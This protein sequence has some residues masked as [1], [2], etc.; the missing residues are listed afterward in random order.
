VT[1]RDHHL[2]SIE[3]EA[4]DWLVLQ[5][6]GPLTPADALVF[7]CWLQRSARHR[8][9][10]EKMQRTWD[11]LAA[12]QQQPG[13]LL[14]HTASL[15]D[16]ARLRQ[17]RRGRQR[18]AAVLAMAASLLVGVLLASL[19]FGD[20][21]AALIADHSSPPGELRTVMLPDGSRADLG[22]STAIKLQFNTAERRV[23]LLGGSAYFTAVPQAVAGGR[24]FIVET[25]TLTARALGTQFLVE[26]LPRGDGVA[27]AEHDVEVTVTGREGAQRPMVLSPGQSLR[28]GRDGQSPATVAS[29]DPQE[30][31]AW[32]RGNLVFYQMPLQEV[33]A[34]LNRYRRSK[35]VLTDDALA[36]RVV[37]GV[38]R[39]GDPDGELRIIAQELGLKVA[40]L[41]F[42]VIIYK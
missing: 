5:T 2:D 14:R 22:P 27:V 32:R 12:L 24:P 36:A 17:A 13:D 40:M 20:P 26:R 8:A 18:V 30:I 31:A 25:G 7:E 16:G 42:F 6:A 15:H 9:A 1:S 39:I 41:P 21:V 11:G 38:F 4:T 34:E 19:W 10:Y 33:V 37:S 35:I 29:I 23:E 3:S 28:Y